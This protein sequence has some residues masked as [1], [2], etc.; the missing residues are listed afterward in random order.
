MT[1]P[2]TI[3]FETEAYDGQPIKSA[4]VLQ[5]AREA[6]QNRPL[7]VKHWADFDSELAIIIVNKVEINASWRTSQAPLTHEPIWDSACMVVSRPLEFQPPGKEPKVS[8]DAPLRDFVE[9]KCPLLSNSERKNIACHSLMLTINEI[10][11]RL[12]NS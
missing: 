4:S 12:N 7:N 11:L 8:L 3:K 10:S 6:L 5:P 2:L 9:C 1:L